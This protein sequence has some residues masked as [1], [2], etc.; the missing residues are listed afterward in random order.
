MVSP[1]YSSSAR[2][3]WVHGEAA[4]QGAGGALQQCTGSTHMGIHCAWGAQ[5]GRSHCGCLWWD[6][7]R[8]DTAAPCGRSGRTQQGPQEGAERCRQRGVGGDC[9]CASGRACALPHS[10]CPQVPST[11]SPLQGEGFCPHPLS[12]LPLV[13]ASSAILP[14]APLASSC[15]PPRMPPSAGS[16]L[17][18]QMLSAWGRYGAHGTLWGHSKPTTCIPLHPLPGRAPRG[19]SQPPTPLLLGDTSALCVPAALCP[20]LLPH[21]ALRGPA[22]PSQHRAGSSTRAFGASRDPGLQEEPWGGSE[23]WVAPCTWHG[24]AVRGLCSAAAP[25]L[26]YPQLVPCP[27]WAQH[28]ALPFSPPSTAARLPKHAPSPWALLHPLC[29]S[30]RTHGRPGRT[31]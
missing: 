30:H 6:R 20:Q 11:A 22:V 2:M 1:N 28:W 7:H 14:P 13:D 18:L 21:T 10:H 25:N 23:N 3:A 19:S 5:Q 26:L 9:L 15:I 17:G 8:C 4:R 24:Q 29:P 12:C 16:I 31:A 27:R